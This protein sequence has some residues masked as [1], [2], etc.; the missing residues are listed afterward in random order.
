MEADLHIDMLS[1]A[2]EAFITSTTKGVVPVIHIGGHD[3]ND[4]QVGTIT[5]DLMSRIN[6]F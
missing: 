5:K 3:I 4:G 2:S 1:Q 6:V